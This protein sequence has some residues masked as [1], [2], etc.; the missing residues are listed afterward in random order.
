[1][2]EDVT[3]PHSAEAEQAV[4][5]AMLLMHEAIDTVACLLEPGQFYYPDHKAIYSTILRLFNANKAVDSLTVYEA[6][7][8]DMAYLVEMTAGCPGPKHVAGYAE[9]VAE[10]WRER[11]MMRI[12]RDIAD[13][14]VMRRNPP[15]KWRPSAPW[16]PRNC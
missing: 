3:P 5:G 1:M 13:D 4:I 10:A 11:E 16:K 8:H 15:V 6:G 2:R 9:I 12:G 14:A 7:R